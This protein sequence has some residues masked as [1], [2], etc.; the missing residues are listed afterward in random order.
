MEMHAVDKLVFMFLIKM[1]VNSRQA[2]RSK[3]SIYLL[4]AT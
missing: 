2:L 3:D 1:S 4:V